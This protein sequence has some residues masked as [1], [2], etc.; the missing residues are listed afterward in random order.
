MILA[1]PLADDYDYKA[2][3]DLDEGTHFNCGPGSSGVYRCVGVGD[4]VIGGF[5]ALQRQINRFASVA[6]FSPITV[7][8][9]PGPGT[10]AAA[11]AV[12][13]YIQK[14]PAT[15]TSL[16]PQSSV[17]SLCAYATSY[18]RSFYEAANT[19][20]LPAGEGDPASPPASTPDLTQLPAP[21]PA[22][23]GAPKKSNTWLWIGGAFLLAAT[24]GTVGYVVYRRRQRRA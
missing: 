17:N 23:A 21:A 8:G 12:I 9:E 7:D 22:P 15:M 24:A 10:L 20:G 6:G 4:D 2:S 19:L 18:V 13:S 3:T 1:M 5:K 14:N 11:Q 16:A